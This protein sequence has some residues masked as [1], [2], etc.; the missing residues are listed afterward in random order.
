M[1]P[2]TRILATLALVVLAAGSARAGP[3][4]ITDDAEPT[5]YHKWEIYNFATGTREGG[6]TSADFGLDLN[7][8]GL[9]DVQLTA[10]LPLHA[11][12]GQ[13]VAAGDVELAVKYKFMHQRELGILPDVAVFPRVF[14]PTG[15]G[16]TS[17]QL[18]LPLWVQKDYGKWSLFGGGGYIL[19]PGPGQLNHWQAGF[20]VNRQ[21]AP[22]FQLGLEYYGAGR[23]AIGERPIHGLNL[24]TQI[25]LKGPFS[26]LGAFGQGLNR[27]QTVFYSSLKLDL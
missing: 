17:A 6:A 23:R 24:G 27:K 25:H 10:T 3:P 22:G 13:S 20:V 14:L 8:G 15:R 9:R 11:E 5:D 1:P 12:S 18:L 19:N 16:S 26:L 4:F 2:R 21:V 7:Y